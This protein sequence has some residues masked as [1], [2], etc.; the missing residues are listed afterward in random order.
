MASTGELYR[1]LQWTREQGEVRAF[2]R[3]RLRLL[4]HTVRE[5]LRLDRVTAETQ[6]SEA[7]L[8]EARAAATE[9]V[10]TDCPF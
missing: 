6:C 5:A 8:S 9:I 7:Y 3:L 4:K 2:E 1:I 10:G